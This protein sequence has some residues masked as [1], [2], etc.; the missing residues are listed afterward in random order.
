MATNYTSNYQLCQWEEDDQVNRLEFNQ[1][2]SRI[3]AGLMDLIGKLEDMKTEIASSVSEVETKMT[4]INSSITGIEKS[5]TDAEKDISTMETTISSL[6]SSMTSVNS[7][8]SSVETTVSTAY[9]TTKPN[10]CYGI[11]DGTGA[12]T[13]LK[14]AQIPTLVCVINVTTTSAPTLEMFIG[15]NLMNIQSGATESLMPLNSNSIL[16]AGVYISSTYSK[17]NNKYLYIAFFN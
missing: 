3:E 16:T 7:S 17:V 13:V 9:T 15:K 6:N 2:N 14:L 8:L 1:D 11:Y 4:A 10:V 5:V 12:L